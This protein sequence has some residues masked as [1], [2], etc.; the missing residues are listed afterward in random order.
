[1]MGLLPTG[2]NSRG[3][4]DCPYVGD[5]QACRWYR[6]CNW[7]PNQ[8]GATGNRKSGSHRPDCLSL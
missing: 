4:A 2:G 1:M 6:K 8:S 3:Q 5:W 7:R